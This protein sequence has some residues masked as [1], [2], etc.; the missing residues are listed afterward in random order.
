MTAGTIDLILTNAT[1]ATASDLIHN[2]EIAIHDGKILCIGNPLPSFM[3]T[4]ASEI[5]D[6]QGRYVTPGGVDSHCHIDQRM[7]DG[8]QCADTFLSATRSSI[9]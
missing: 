7:E 2:A 8:S 3:H 6:C 5:I 9:A 1:L 4:S